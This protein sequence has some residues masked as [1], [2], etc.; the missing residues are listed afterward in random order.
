MKIQCTKF[1][2]NESFWNVKILTIENENR[3]PN[4][5]QLLKN[6]PKLISVK[7]LVTENKKWSHN[8]IQLL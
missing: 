5:T 7:Q 1:G 8:E 2:K 3:V 4:E 6:E